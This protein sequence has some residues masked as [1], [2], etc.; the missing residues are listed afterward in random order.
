MSASEPYAKPR[1]TACGLMA[2]TTLARKAHA[3]LAQ[4]FSHARITFAFSAFG[5][6]HQSIRNP[7]ARDALIF[8]IIILY[9]YISVAHLPICD[10]LL[11]RDDASKS[12]R[13]GIRGV[14]VV[15]VV[16]ECAQHCWWAGQ[17]RH[18]HLESSSEFRE[19]Y[20]SN[21]RNGISVCAYR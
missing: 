6:M 16:I 17:K 11:A 15:C 8:H 5:G 4:S 2:N 13:A 9:I 21:V 14:G 10:A 19:P 7:A 18:N 3:F 1:P 20:Y 12:R